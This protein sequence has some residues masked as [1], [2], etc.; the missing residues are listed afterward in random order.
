MAKALWLVLWGSLAYFAVAGANRSAQGL[1]DLLS[2]ES[3]GEPSWVAWIDRHAAALV[4][5]QGLG[6]SVAVA[7]LLAAVAIGVYLPARFAQVTIALGVILAA[8][9]WVVGQN[10]GALFTNGATDVNSGPLLILL[11]VAF[12]P[13]ARAVKGV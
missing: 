10:F 5:H 4:A 1:H 2:S 6:V 13:P 8:V 9:F 12:W 3:S 11:C 7:V